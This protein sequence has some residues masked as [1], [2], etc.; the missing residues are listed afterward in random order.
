[1]KNGVYGEAANAENGL[2]FSADGGFDAYGSIYFS[3]A[4]SGDKAVLNIGSN[5]EVAADYSVDGQF[6]F[7]IGNKQ[8]VYYVKF[9]SEALYQDLV[10]GISSVK[11]AINDG[12]IYDLQGRQVKA[13]KKGLYI[14]NGHKVVIK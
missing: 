5:D 10:Q 12:N 6:C 2:A 13:A 11:A 1:M 8:Y 4:K 9:L 14:Q 3:I 7:E